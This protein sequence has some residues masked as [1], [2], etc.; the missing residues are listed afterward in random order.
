MIKELKDKFLENNL[1]DILSYQSSITEPRIDEDNEDKP[2]FIFKSEQEIEPGHYTFQVD[3]VT[4]TDAFVDLW[5]Y[6]DEDDA[7]YYRCTSYYY[8]YN[9]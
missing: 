4:F 7:Q 6:D 5:Y 8:N 1:S 9:F 2:E 3:N